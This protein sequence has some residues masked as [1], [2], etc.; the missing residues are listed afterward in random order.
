MG[1]SDVADND[2]VTSVTPE[3]AAALIGHY[4]RLTSNP[5][6]QVRRGRLIG[7]G[8]WEQTESTATIENFYNWGVS[9]NTPYFECFADIIAPR[10]GSTT[11]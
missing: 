11:P 1:R 2:I 6:V 3:D 5:V 9:A 8:T 7:G 10:S 4:L